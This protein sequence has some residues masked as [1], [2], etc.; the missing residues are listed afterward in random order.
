MR[1]NMSCMKLGAAIGLAAMGLLGA[2]APSATAAWKAGTAR[3]AITPKQPMWMAGYAARTKPSEG[4][5]HDLWAKALA[6]EDPAGR[7]AILVTLDV[8]GIDRELS[9]RIR[10]TLKSGDGL[11]RDQIVL[12]CSHTHSGPVVG[13]N[14]LTMYKIDDAER[15]RIAAYA[16]FLEKSVVTVAEQALDRLEEPRLSWGTG[17]CDFAVNRRNNKEADVPELRARLALQGP[18]DHDVPGAAGRREPTA[19]LLAIVFGYACHCTVLDS[20]QF[21]GDYAG[22]AQIDLEKHA[23]RR[24]GDVRRR[25]RRR[26]EPDSRARTLELAARYGKQLAASVGERARR[27]RYGRSTARLR[28]SLRRDHAR[29]RHAADPGADRERHADRTT[30]TSPAGPS[31]CSRTSKAQGELDPTYPYPVQVW[32]LGRAD[33]GLPGRRGRRRLFAAAQAQP[34]LVAH[35]GLGLLQRRD[36]IYP[37]VAGAQRRGLRRG[38]GDDLLRSACGLVGGCRG[39]DRQD[40][41]AGNQSGPPGASIGTGGSSP[42]GTLTGPT[43]TTRGSARTPDIHA[44]IAMATHKKADKPMTG[45]DTPRLGGAARPERA[46]RDRAGVNDHPDPHDHAR[47]GASGYRELDDRLG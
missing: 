25:L 41:R 47:A 26:P 37:L 33:L 5:V 46:K 35:V 4:A 7:R 38:D 36:G 44:T 3:I 32:R 9:N 30:S 20:Y 31:I 29:V 14:L 18:V 24:P 45:R 39:R 23:S 34:R 16:Q 27:A 12:A 28:T 2:V 40:R 8:C 43:E 11:G 19:A 15:Q 22:F 10:D 13:T 42:G 21:C 1:N 17:R 6:L